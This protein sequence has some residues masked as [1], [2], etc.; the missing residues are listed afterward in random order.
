[1]TQ[2]NVLLDRVIATI[3][4]QGAPSYLYYAERLVYFPLG[5]FG[6]ALGTV[7][8]PTFS[9]HVVQARHD[10][11]RQT[12]NH[13]IRQLTFLALPAAIGMLVLARPIIQ[14][15]YE[16]GGFT[17]FTTEMTVLALSFY[18]PGLVVFSLLKILIPVFYAQQ[19]MKTPVRI[20][21]I[22]TCIS[23]ILKLILMWPMRHAGIAFSTVIAT[24][25]EVVILFVL[26]HRRFGS[27]GWK[28]I[29][30]AVLKMAGAAG[31]MVIAALMINRICMQEFTALN[32]SL[33]LT[34]LLSLIT[35]LI[36]AVMTY[37][38]AALLLRCG[39]AV[40]LWGALRQRE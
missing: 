39:E 40:E 32:F 6:T 28:N 3:I 33:Q 35:A 27:L 9:T 34:R 30:M 26:I 29:S 19:D 2:I 5:I 20:G 37:F 7:L 12:L 11:V 21:I 24:S 22:C 14:V 10:L 18:A 31:L 15:I 13:S 4:G 1:V 23:I 8:L 17:P 25:V 38:I 16:R 36:T